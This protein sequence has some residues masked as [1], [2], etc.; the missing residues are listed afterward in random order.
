MTSLSFPN[1]KTTEANSIQNMFYNCSS[2]T[3]LYLP[4]FET[5]KIANENIEGA[6]ENC[7]KLVLSIKL[8]QCSNLIENI[9]DYITII[10]L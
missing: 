3:S 2:L 1:L 4:F 8:E 6:F 9:P 7:Q 10:G 5:N